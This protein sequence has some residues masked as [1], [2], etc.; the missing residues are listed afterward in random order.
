[1]NLS[2]CETLDRRLTSGRS[3]SNV[4]Q[5]RRAS[6]SPTRLEASTWEA[7]SALG[8]DHARSDDAPKA[9]GLGSSSSTITT[10]RA[11]SKSRRAWAGASILPRCLS[12]RYAIRNA[13]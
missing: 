9:R 7:G 8:H 2:S 5:H 11:L 6:T 3:P 1:M 10:T 12:P 4:S 13:V